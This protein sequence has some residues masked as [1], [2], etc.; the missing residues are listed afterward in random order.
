MW[1][2][3][4]DQFFHN[5]KA[6]AVGPEGRELFVASVCYSAMQL[7][8]G[9]F[10]AED[11]PVIAALAQ[12]ERSVADRLLAHEMWHPQGHDCPKCR[13]VGQTMPVP[14]GYI[15]VHEYLKTN[16]SRADVEAERAAAAERQRRSREK[17]RRDSHGTANGSHG[18]TS[19][20]PSRP[21]T[22]FSSTSSSLA[23]HDADHPPEED[24]EISTGN[25]PA[26]TWKRYAELKL[27]R[28]PAGT[29]RSAGP[30]K[31]KTAATAKTEHGEQAER[32]WAMF[33]I[34]AR[35][36]AECLID[37]RAPRNA[38][39]RQPHQPGPQDAA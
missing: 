21:L 12:V 16:P 20:A 10:V 36:L 28:E 13:S 6:R 17:S 4:D 27:E 38:P 25:V 5:R 35:R 2:R 26:E 14:P 33:D 18:V 19:G 32:W 11:L 15:A 22:E 24:D 23:T 30:W 7:N 31:R 9:Q 1:V 29:V 37:G 39:L 8:D 34:T 3:I